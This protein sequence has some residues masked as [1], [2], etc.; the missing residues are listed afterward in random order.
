MLK[1]E[2]CERHLKMAAEVLQAG[3]SRPLNAKTGIQSKKLTRLS[4][5]AWISSRSRYP[6]LHLDCRAIKAEGVDTWKE[7]TWVSSSPR[8]SEKT[9]IVDWSYWH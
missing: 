8:K 5:E 7:N 2:V 1:K 3:N 6:S 9:G 4:V